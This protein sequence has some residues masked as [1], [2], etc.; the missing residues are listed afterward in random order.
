MRLF[1][2]LAATAIAAIM[3]LAA[4]NSTEQQR[5]A[6]NANTNTAGPA[7]NPNTPASQ[8]APATPSDGVRR[9]TP[10]ELKQAVDSGS[11]IIVDVRGASAYET[12]HI[13]GAR[14]IP[15]DQV[16]AK[17]EELPRDKMIVTYCS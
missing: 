4:C 8:S 9:V 5:A 1:L 16:L 6:G 7:P 15:T 2:S 17:A 11:A 14:W 10:A 3:L 13:K 12:A